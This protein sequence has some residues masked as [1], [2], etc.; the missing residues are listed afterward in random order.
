[1]KIKILLLVLFAVSLIAAAGCSSNDPE[2]EKAQAEM[3]KY[4]A[5]QKQRE[6]A[7]VPA[8]KVCSI[9]KKWGIPSE[10]PEYKGTPGS[11]YSCGTS[12]RV[13]NQGLLYGASG[14]N[15]KVSTAYISMSELF[16]RGEN[17]EVLKLLVEQGNELS[18]AFAGQPLS[19]EIEAA[20][21]DSKPGEW[22]LGEA[23][24]K[25]EKKEPQMNSYDLVLTFSL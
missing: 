25:L 5:E 22:K 9:Y 21:T 20:I 1:M 4:N 3:D 10:S 14:Y 2:A 19:K 6:E 16:K 11:L 17:R 18:Q 8:D 24:V 13:G 23:K 12:R 7:G 15:N